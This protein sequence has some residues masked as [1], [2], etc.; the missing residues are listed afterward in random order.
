MRRIY[1]PAAYKRVAQVVREHIEASL[2]APGEQLPTI[3]Q[4]AVLHEVT[5]SVAYAALQ[6]LCDQGLVVARRGNGYYVNG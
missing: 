1:P 5:P 6:L 3:A 2:Y 4:L